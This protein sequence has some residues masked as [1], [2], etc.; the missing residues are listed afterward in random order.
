MSHPEAWG[1]ETRQ[2]HAGHVPDAEAS[3]RAVPIYQTTAFTFRDTKHAS[4]LFD[5][6]EVGNIYTR[7]M[8]PTQ[9]VL[10]S[11]VAALEGAPDTALG[12]PGALAVAS[13][14][15]ATTLAILNLAG[16]G[17]HIVSSASLYGGTYNLLHHTLRKLGIDVSF[18]DDVDD[19]EEWKAAV[20]PNTKAFFGESIGNPRNDIF[21]LEG[22]SAV[23]HEAGLPLIIDNTVATP[24]LI[25][26]IEWGA[27]IVVHSATKF[28]GGHGNSMAGIIVDGGTFDFSASG[29]FPGFT[30]P[31]ESYHGL[32]YWEALGP[33]AFILKARV[34]LL[35]DMGNAISPFNAFLVIQG[36]ETLSLRMERH[37]ANTAKVIDHLV[38][39]PQVEKIKW[40]GLPS[41]P[42]HE[43]GK[44]YGQ[45]RG[46]G[47]VPAFIIKGGKEAGQRFVEALELHSHVANLGDVRSLCIHPA[48]TTHSQL[49]DAEQ[50]AAGVE[51]GLVR[52]SVGIESVEDIIA[53]LDNGF[54]A[55]K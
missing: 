44:K 23:A 11:R 33:G 49:S 39:H 18:I 53:D 55:A 42:W 45:G 51:P 34:Q 27:D 7:I 52:L 19:L 37:F 46:F 41:S 29:R 15:S 26:P 35:R 14:Q 47:S 36:V 25:R 24:Y 40:A 38:D 12:I 4:D 3:A 13:G 48:S 43:L 8:N 32:K 28:L 16:A 22:V 54:R 2:V 30:E 17:D 20:R 5:L 50:L 9:A 1:F 31:D 6:A 21:N 10:E